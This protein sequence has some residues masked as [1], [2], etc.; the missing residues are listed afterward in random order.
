VADA[1]AGRVEP[2]TDWLSTPADLDGSM[3]LLRAPL[4]KV[5]PGERVFRREFYAR[6]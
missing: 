5:Q 4:L 1:V 6:R 3:I 2:A